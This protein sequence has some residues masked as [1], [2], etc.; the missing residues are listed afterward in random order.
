MFLQ[1]EAKG[2]L[3]LG[4][5]FHSKRNRL[6]FLYIE[7]R[8]L[9]VCFNY[10]FL[11]RVHMNVYVCTYMDLP[12]CGKGL[13]INKIA[14]LCLLIILLLSWLLLYSL[15]FCYCFVIL[16]FVLLEENTFFSHCVWLFSLFY[17][18]SAAKF[19]FTLL[20][21]WRNF[22]IKFPHTCHLLL[23]AITTQHNNKLS[24]SNS[25]SNT[26]S[27]TYPIQ[28]LNT[29]RHTR[30]VFFFF[31]VISCIFNAFTHPV[32]YIFFVFFFC[33]FLYFIKHFQYN[34]NVK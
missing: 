6:Y 31:S 16:F 19:Y 11:I 13:R 10:S 30:R 12:E 27:Y 34:K 22:N 21:F 32:L 26:T 3:I 4:E 24:S 17:L 15:L 33:F 25:S 29:N 5:R 28:D 8:H 18:D 23:C 20:W 14:Y 7:K 9:K 1:D 2:H